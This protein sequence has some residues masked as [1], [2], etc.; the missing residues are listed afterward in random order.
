MAGYAD[1]LQERAGEL[2]RQGERLLAAIRTKP[3]GSTVGAAGGLI[4]EA[5]SHRAAS[6]SGVEAGAGSQAETWPRENS[7]VGMTDQRILIFNYTAMGKPKDLIGEFPLDQ[8]TSVEQEKKLTANVIRFVFADGSGAEV[9]CAKLEKTGPF[10]DA[11]QEAK[12][13]R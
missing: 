9:E 3:R 4:G 2:L 13:G 8:V 6:K 10:V 1:K 5:L 12:S 7:A 11:F